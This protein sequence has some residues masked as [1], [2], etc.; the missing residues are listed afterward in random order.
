MED[1]TKIFLEKSVEAIIDAGLSPTDLS[2]T[3]TS[4]FAGSA[5]SETGILMWDPT[6]S[7]L[8]ALLGRSR[9]MQANRVSYFLNLTGI[10]ILDNHNFSKY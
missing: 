3:N 10:L 5:I 9:A 7:G 2:G 6:Y 1:L 8:F 4:V